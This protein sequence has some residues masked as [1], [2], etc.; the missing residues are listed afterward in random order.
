MEHWL[1]LMCCALAVV[2]VLYFGDIRERS[3][4][5]KRGDKKLLK[6]IFKLKTI[7]EYLQVYIC[8]EVRLD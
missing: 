5:V 1:Q 3:R 7:V 4:K 8:T 6:L 2:L